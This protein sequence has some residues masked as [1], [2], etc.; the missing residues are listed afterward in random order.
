MDRVAAVPNKCKACT[1]LLELII[2]AGLSRS[3][4]QE[5]LVIVFMLIDEVDFQIL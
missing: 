2:V 4:S 5:N 3:C 1:I